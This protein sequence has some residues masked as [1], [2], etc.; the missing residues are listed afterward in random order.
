MYDRIYEKIYDDFD[1]KIIGSNTEYLESFRKLN[2][3]WLREY[4]EISAY[5]AKV[6]ADPA[7]QIMQN[8]GR[9][10]CMFLG[11]EVVG[12]YAL[13]KVNADEWELSKFTIKNK[14]RGRKLGKK[15]LQHAIKQ[16]EIL[17]ARSILLFTH[18]N[19]R[20]ATKLYRDAGFKDIEGHPEMRDPTGRCSILMKLNINT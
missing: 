19:L 7:G 20:E 6:L 15:L 16:A 13:Q 8:G 11:N 17:D 1:I 5:D 18:T 9:I 14:F 10:Y 4:L 2:E 12:T 3:D